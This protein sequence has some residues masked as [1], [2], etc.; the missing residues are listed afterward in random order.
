MKSLE[1]AV[2]LLS[3][4]VLYE[5]ALKGITFL[6]FGCFIFIFLLRGVS[7]CVQSPSTCTSTVT[8]NS[9]VSDEVEIKKLHAVLIVPLVKNR[10]YAFIFVLLAIA[11]VPRQ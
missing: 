7:A 6:I 8:N 4:V 3:F 2:R 9:S 5:Y 10:V 1:A 11:T